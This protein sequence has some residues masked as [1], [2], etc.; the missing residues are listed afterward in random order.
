MR[1]FNISNLASLQVTASPGHLDHAI[2]HHLQDLQCLIDLGVLGRFK[3]GCLT[4]KTHLAGDVGCG[5]Q[6]AAPNPPF[7]FEELPK[8][9]WSAT[10]DFFGGLVIS[11]Y[12]SKT[13]GWMT[14]INQLWNVNPLRGTNITYPIQSQ[15]A[16][17]KSM[18]FRFPRWDRLVSQAGISIIRSETR[19]VLPVLGQ[20]HNPLTMH[21]AVG[22]KVLQ[23]WLLA[24][25]F[26]VFIFCL[27][28]QTDFN[29]KK[30]VSKKRNRKT[31]K[32]PLNHPDVFVGFDKRMDLFSAWR[33]FGRGIFVS[34]FWTLHDLKNLFI[35]KQ[36]TPL[37]AACER[38]FF[39]ILSGWNLHLSSIQQPGRKKTIFWKGLRGEKPL[40]D[41][42][43]A[44]LRPQ[45]FYKFPRKLWWKCRPALITP[46]EL[47]II[48]GLESYTHLDSSILPT[49]GRQRHNWWNRTASCWS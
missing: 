47:V 46:G 38:C 2:K 6:N 37:R 29:Q 1:F 22:L 49:N 10:I 39:L 36:K 19:P 25:I 30:K 13:W 28:G 35:W 33:I 24:G 44:M 31:Q 41:F 27:R 40:L 15:K 9:P 16:L 17:L 7:F 12:S 26:W 45:R 18:I 5:V 8:T 32:K 4:Y 42:A 3:G 14:S 23:T 48:Y 34:A 21:R 43:E 11:V 20:R